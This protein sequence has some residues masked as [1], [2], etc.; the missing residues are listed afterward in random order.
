MEDESQEAIEAKAREQGWNPDYDGPN[1]TD[2]KT[3][4]EKG[5][6]IAGILKSRVD[7]QSVEIEQL[8]RSN[9]EFGEY[10][11]VQRERERK[12]FQEQIAELEN[13]KATAI[14]DADGPEV[15]RIEREIESVRSDL[16]SQSNGESQI[17]SPEA[18]AWEA[19][20]NEWYDTDPDLRA[21]TAGV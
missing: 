1:K 9:I 2:A 15:V 14:T 3:F 16:P 6:K 4:V 20:G 7:R 5:E 13:K 19:N 17:R 21:D 10:T 18:A 11:K 12:A 8:K